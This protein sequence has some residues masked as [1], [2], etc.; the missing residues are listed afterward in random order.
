MWIEQL[1][2]SSPNRLI[3]NIATFGRIGFREI[4]H[5]TIF[6]SPGLANALG[7]IFYTLFLYQTS[8]LNHLFIITI[9]IYFG[10]II[11]DE[12]S[13]R[14]N[15]DDP[16]EIVLDEFVGGIIVFFGSER[17]IEHLGSYAW[18]FLIAGILLFGFIDWK[19]P[20][21]IHKVEN[22]PTWGI[23]ADDVLAG[24]T[25]CLILQISFQI[26]F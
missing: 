10:S 15:K 11:C 23:M 19:K 18:I 7:A 6:N 17:I 3:I 21:I 25:S 14:L 5:P 9:L 24:I 2:R 22:L 13:K 1:I 12:A 8:W 16:K 4:E 26:F 20:W